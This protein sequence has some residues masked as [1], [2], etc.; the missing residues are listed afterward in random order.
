M[1]LKT[2]LLFCMLTTQLWANDRV[3]YP[4]LGVQFSIP[5]GW[6]GFEDEDAYV[7]QSA[8]HAGALIMMLNPAQS[9]TELKSQADAGIVDGFTTMLSRQSDFTQIGA[10]GLGADF[11]GFYEGIP[12]KAFVI[13]LINPFGNSLMIGA[14]TEKNDFSDEY[15]QLAI[16]LANSVA[17]AIPQDSQQTL[18]W[19]QDL[20]GNS[21]TYLKSSYSSGA[22][23]VD[24]SGMSFGTYSSYSSR[25]VIS[26]CN[27]QRFNFYFSSQ[28][29][30]DAG[31]GF[32]STSSGDDSQGNWQ[33]TTDNDGGSTLL[34]RFDNGE[35]RR[36]SL[37][38]ENGRTYLNGDRY[39]L[40]DAKGC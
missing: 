30:F 35:E 39:Y 8:Q 10:E 34:L 20:P 16:N 22:S 14:V 37:L 28:S 27:A 18:A 6:Q 9:I 40:G 5:A 3:D 2:I 33:I 25:R 26:F 23:Y 31:G 17:F 15:R 13:G 4:Y 11:A 32:G 19:R 29:S 1:K 38:S 36:Y 7:M 24:S 12:A 21:L